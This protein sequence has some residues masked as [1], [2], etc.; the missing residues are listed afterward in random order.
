MRLVR[1]DRRDYDLRTQL[2]TSTYSR[3]LA[4]HL[5]ARI[6][7]RHSVADTSFTDTSTNDAI[8]RPKNDRKLKMKEATVICTCA[9]VGLARP[10]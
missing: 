9:R 4:L 7:I 3:D 10:Q 6:S 2:K 1:A 8:N 5:P